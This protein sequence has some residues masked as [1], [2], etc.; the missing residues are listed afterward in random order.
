MWFE[1]KSKT[2]SLD[3]ISGWLFAWTPK[4]GRCRSGCQD[5]GRVEDYKEE[6]EDPL[7][8]G[9]AR[10]R[11]GEG[12]ISHRKKAFRQREKGTH[13]TTHFQPTADTQGFTSFQ[14]FNDRINR[15][16]AAK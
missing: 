13:L 6:L 8:A 9:N 15:K 14:S 2:L 12:R 11:G 7:P 4:A 16:R 5:L 10:V 3:T 1:N